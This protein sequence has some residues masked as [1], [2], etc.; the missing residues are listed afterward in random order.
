[1]RK[2]KEAR[3]RCSLYDEDIRIANPQVTKKAWKAITGVMNDL[4]GVPS[5]ASIDEAGQIISDTFTCKSSI[6]T[7]PKLQSILNLYYKLYDKLN[8]YLELC[9]MDDEDFVVDLTTFGHHIV[10]LEE[11][12]EKTKWFTSSIGNISEPVGVSKPQIQNIGPNP[13]LGHQKIYNTQVDAGNIPSNP[14]RPTQYD[15]PIQQ[16]MFGQM[17]QQPH[18][19]PIGQQFSFNQPQ[20]INIGGGYRIPLR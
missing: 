16:P 7:V 15:Q 2:L 12:Y 19:M 6:I 17:V 20:R 18:H 13:I 3:F 8:P 10:H 11:Y 5:V 9:N 1:M 4:L 14:L